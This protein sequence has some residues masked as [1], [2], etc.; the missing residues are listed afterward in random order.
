MST[1]S[2]QV[3]R[4]RTRTRTG[5]WTCRA[6]RKKCDECHPHCKTC[7]DL[8]LNCEGYEVRL[9]WGVHRKPVTV[10]RKSR[11]RGQCAPPSRKRDTALHD[12]AISNMEQCKLQAKNDMLLKYLDRQIFDSL[13]E[14]ERELLHECGVLTLTV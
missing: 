13:R 8:A 3:K 6:R 4:V 14:Y 1:T 5:C 12:G 11:K 2:S 10:Q 7:T 9:K